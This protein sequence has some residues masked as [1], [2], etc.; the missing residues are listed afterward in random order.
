MRY[1]HTDSSLLGIAHHFNSATLWRVFGLAQILLEEKPLTVRRALYAGQGRELFPDTSD[2]RY[3]CCSRLIL[4]LRRYGFV[5]Y[6]WIVDSTRR[7]LKPSSWSRLADYAET[8]A[9]CYR[10]NLWTSQPDYI[11]IF[12]EKDAMAGVIEPVTDRYDVTLN[13]I[14]GNCSET[15]V[16]RVAELWKKIK[17]PIFAYYLGD[18]DP[19]GLRI[20]RDLQRRLNGS[21]DKAF[22]WQRLAVTSE[23]FANQDLLGFPVKRKGSPGS[24]RPYL[25]I[26]DDRCVEV[27]AIPTT[28]IR[29]RVE[30]AILNHVDQHEWALL[31]AQEEREKKD[32]FELVKELGA[33]AA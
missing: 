17:K 24:W 10:K 11:E 23:D 26:Y 7:R 19:S 25:E 9:Q 2:Q 32:I 8:V 15:F 1:R 5:P 16:Y 18:H 31:Q 13:N 28:E 6:D 22:H 14:R 29:E 20:E 33:R 3:A 21:L 27:D 12:C 4:C 30:T